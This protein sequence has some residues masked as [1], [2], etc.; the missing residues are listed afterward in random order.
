MSD[1]SHDRPEALPISLVYASLSKLEKFHA[2]ELVHLGVGPPWESS[3]ERRPLPVQWCSGRRATL[4]PLP[5]DPLSQNS[6]AASISLWSDLYSA[7]LVMGRRDMSLAMLPVTFT[8]PCMKAAL[9]SSSP[10]CI[11]IASS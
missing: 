1:S 9:A 2:N 4:P 10:F 6:V 3:L 5:G 7:E 11:R 8:R